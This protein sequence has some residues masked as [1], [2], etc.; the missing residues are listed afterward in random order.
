MESGFEQQNARPAPGLEPPVEPGGGPSLRGLSLVARIMR[1]RELA[2]DAAG[3]PPLD[4]DQVLDLQRTAGNSLTTGALAR[5]TEAPDGA[6]LLDRL[7]PARAT[8]PALHAQVCAE[9]DALDLQLLVR[10]SC[11]EGPGQPVA[12]DIRGPAGGAAFG[13]ATL[14]P[15]VSATAELPFAIA[16]GA[17]ASIAPG[18]GLALRL[19]APDGS[20]AT[21]I[22]ALPFADAET[23]ALGRSRY[24]AL[25]EAR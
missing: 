20:A 13:S 6:V 22:L 23:L 5:W 24:V 21:A 8:D 2:A 7:L 4:S 16:F 25:A 9:L 3:I 17:A 12:I 1:G 11:T 10:V 15:D 18:H 14:P 19:T